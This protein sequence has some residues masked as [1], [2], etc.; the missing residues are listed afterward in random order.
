[1]AMLTLISLGGAKPRQL[2][3]KYLSHAEQAHDVVCE[4]DFVPPKD[5]SLHNAIC[6]FEQGD[7]GGQPRFL[8]HTMGESARDQS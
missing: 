3:D 6:R 4:Q 2:A 7:N 5:G 8:H 1:M